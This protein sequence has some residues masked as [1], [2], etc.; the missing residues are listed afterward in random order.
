M[1][2]LALQTQAWLL[3]VDPRCFLLAQGPCELRKAS[4]FP[5]IL[6]M[7]FSSPCTFGVKATTKGKRGAPLLAEQEESLPGWGGLPVAFCR[8]VSIYSME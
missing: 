1:E 4:A 3:E 6:G 7:L 5:N 2:Q 8:V